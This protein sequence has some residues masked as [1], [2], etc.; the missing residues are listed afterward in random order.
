[1]LKVPRMK[2]NKTLKLNRTLIIFGTFLTCLMG[3]A[4]PMGWAQDTTSFKITSIIIKKN[5]SA[6]SDPTAIKEFF[7]RANC[8]CESKVTLKFLIEGKYL[9]NVDNVEG[10]LKVIAGQNC[11]NTTD[12]S[13]KL[14]DGECRELASKTDVDKEFE[15]ADKT[16]LDLLTKNITE[17][18]GVDSESFSIIVYDDSNNDDKFTELKKESFSVDL[19]PPNNPS[20]L[21][22]SNAIKPG[23]GIISLSFCASPKS[24]STSEES[25]SSEEESNSSEEESSSSSNTDLGL[26][27]YQILCRKKDNP[28]VSPLDSPPAP[29]FTSKATLCNDAECTT[30]Y[31]GSASDAGSDATSTD[32]KD[33]ESDATN[34]SS[35]S[36]NTI[37][38]C[39]KYVCSELSTSTSQKISGLTNDVT[40]EFWVVAI[41]KA[42]NPSDPIYLGEGTPVPVKPWYEIYKKAKGR[43]DG[44]HCFVATAAYGNYDHPQVRILRAFRDQVLLK[45]TGGRHF[46]DLYY[47]ASPPLAAWI[48]KH[49][50]ARFATRV[51]LWPVTIAAAFQL[52]T[53]VWLKLFVLFV[54]SLVVFL[55]IQRR[56]RHLR[57]AKRA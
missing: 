28:N 35:S 47:R 7:N 20:K 55:W 16:I 2:R 33:A 57:S 11:K 36:K 5:G 53:S 43:N 15:I 22:D 23:S 26:L 29:Q 54:V 13:L 51:L 50:S 31:S 21:S 19:E 32:G 17:C 38:L 46:V 6:L 49:P 30:T 42:R 34:N 4:P 8:Q 41:D 52:Y 18:K 1:M 24:N 48:V 9:K 14:G 10:P 12:E 25:S 40:Y 3:I 44:G 45:S 27:G 37:P 56:K 39:A